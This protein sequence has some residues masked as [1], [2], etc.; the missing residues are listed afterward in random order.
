MLQE[1]IIKSALKTWG[2]NTQLDMV[3]EEMSELAKAILKYKRGES[4]NSIIE[5]H[6]DVSI[7][8]DQ[9]TYMMSQHDPLYVEKVDKETERKTARLVDILERAN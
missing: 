3:I 2:E 7:M 1:H 9:L 6:A 4:I 5:E 8:L